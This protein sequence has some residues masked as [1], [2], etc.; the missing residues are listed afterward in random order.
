MTRSTLV[1]I[2]LLILAQSVNGQTERGPI[3]DIHLHAYSAFEPNAE[4]STWIPLYLPLPP[5]DSLLM[6]RT[7]EKLDEYN[8]E[9]AVLSG[10]LGNVSRWAERAPG[11]FIRGIQVS[12]ITGSPESVAELRGWIESGQVEAFGE[13]SIQYRGIRMDDDRVMPY[14]ALLEELDIPLLVHLG[15]GPR[16]GAVREG[17]RYTVAAG[18]PLGLERVLREHPDLRVCI[19]HAGWPLGDEVIGLLH[20]YPQVYVGVGVINWYIARAEFYSYL[21]RIIDAGYANR[22]LFGSDQMNWPDAIDLAIDAIDSAPF[23]SDEQKRAIFYSNAVQFLKL[24]K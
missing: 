4:D 1:V 9:R 21:K 23:L 15:L 20:S 17:S 22:V 12:D 18:D 5:S 2:S 16:H 13:F 8:I 11:R 10:P 6:E 7:L 19:L 14:M 24:D 3:I